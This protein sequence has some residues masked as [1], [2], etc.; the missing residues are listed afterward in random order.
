MFGGFAW[1]DL[2]IRPRRFFGVQ[3]FTAHSS[4]TISVCED[5]AEL[6]APGRVLV[7]GLFFRVHGI[8]FTVYW[9]KQNVQPN[10]GVCFTMGFEIRF[11]NR[12]DLEGFLESPES[13]CSVPFPD[14]RVLGY[15][16]YQ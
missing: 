14:L 9:E 1:G 4:N 3:E 6:D 5:S 12:T 2:Q 10:T 11:A 15:P 7:Q 8:Y 16:R 13:R